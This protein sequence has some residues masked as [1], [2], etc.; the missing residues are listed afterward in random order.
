MDNVFIFPVNDSEANGGFV[1]ADERCYDLEAVLKSIHD[2]DRAENLREC[3]PEG[4]CYIWALPDRGEN[5]SI[6]NLISENDL[7]LAFRSGS[8]IAAASVLIKI[9]SPSLA[10]NLWGADAEGHSRL[11]CFS[12]RP[13]TGEV[14]LIPQMER[15]LD[16]DFK[17]FTRLK[18]EKRDNILSDYGSLEI[19]VR[20]GLKYDF[21]FSFRH[22]E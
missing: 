2:A 17:G 4:R 16:R 12:R 21:P 22:S 7:V 20:L 11:M 13:Y 10:E 9:E 15:Y 14:P 8:I 5:R 18:K 6:W 19:F 1:V 3:C